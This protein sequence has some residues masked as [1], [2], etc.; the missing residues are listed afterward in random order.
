MLK[1]SREIPLHHLISRQMQFWETV[2]REKKKKNDKRS[3][4]SLTISREIGSQGAQLAKKLGE[5]LSWQVFDR[6]IVDYIANNAH[7]RKEIVELFDGKTRSELNNWVLTI[8]DSH[9]L[10]S[11]KFFKH[12]VTTLLSIAQHGKAVILGRG[13][14]FILPD[15]KAL[16]LRVIAPYEKRVQFVRDELGISAKE[17]AD[18][19]RKVQNDR[20][21]FIKRFFRADPSDSSNFDLVLNMGK[22]DLKTAEE[23]A[24]AALTAKFYLKE[25]ALRDRGNGLT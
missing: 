22:L 25:N 23:I 6:E 19:I 16:K 12:L 10:S 5:R 14:N 20:I 15:D 13:G 2:H 3:Y 1:I 4:P 18:F 21:A 8:L 24:I 7:V 11:D 17:A 9:A